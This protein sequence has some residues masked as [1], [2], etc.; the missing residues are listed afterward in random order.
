M[1]S[2]LLSD[3]NNTDDVKVDMQHFLM[4]RP[5]GQFPLPEATKALSKVAF[6]TSVRAS[7]R[8]KRPNLKK[9]LFLNFKV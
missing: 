9:K 2:V 8:R 5:E 1:N 3:A 7:G 6:I 4:Y